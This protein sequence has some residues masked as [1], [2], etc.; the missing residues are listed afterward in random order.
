MNYLRFDE[1]VQPSDI[2]HYGILGMRWGVRNAETRAR[3]A[4]TKGDAR[5]AS[6]RDYKKLIKT[7]QRQE[8]KGLTDGQKTALKIAVGTAA[9]VA[10]GTISVKLASSGLAK[11][12][13]A[14]KMVAGGFVTK[15]KQMTP[16]QDLAAV[17]R[18][19]LMGEGYQH[20]CVLCSTAYDLRR[21]G[22]DV[23]A[24]SSTTGFNTNIFFG[25][26]YQ[27][28]DGSPL[29]MGTI[30]SKAVQSTR[31]RVTAQVFSEYVNKYGADMTPI[32]KEAMRVETF[33]RLSREIG[34]GSNNPKIQPSIDE[35]K[36]VLL[37]QGEGA[38]GAISV[39]WA[40]F[41]GH[42]IAYEVRGGQVHFPDG[43]INR[44]HDLAQLLKRTS[45]GDGIGFVR[46]DNA[47]PNLEKLAADGRI[48]DTFGAA[49]VKPYMKK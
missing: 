33:K 45:Y 26:Y 28:A 43:Q 18:R 13:A 39:R 9:V 23:A 40:L 25:T 3:Y 27:K 7:A 30:T 44:E 49:A 46:L 48:R 12:A 8:R 21:R 38:R 15:A 35:V 17:N 24:G 36:T 16:D 4:R 22:Y 34:M 2:S 41:G 14:R 29:D 42:S 6:D 37:A 10:A 32:A 19:Y 5:I 47:E 31:E 1:K 20:N 11:S